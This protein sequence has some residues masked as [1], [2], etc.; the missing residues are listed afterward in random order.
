MDTLTSGEQR[1]FATYWGIKRLE[2]REEFWEDA[3]RVFLTEQL[4]VALPLKYNPV[5]VRMILDMLDCGE[6]GDCC[7]YTKIPITQQDV[8]RIIEHTSYTQKSLKRVV[9][10]KDNELYLSGDCPFLKDNSCTI[11]KWRPDTCYLFPIQSSKAVWSVD[12]EFT[13]QMFFRI[14]CRQALAVV[15]TIFNKAMTPN[16]LLLP[17]LTL[18]SSEVA[19]MKKK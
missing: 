6:C 7:R 9:Q 17:N 11:Y 19:D 2:K 13:Q 16:R 3:Y 8:E 4:N 10:T 18:I 15:R 14:K 12:G 1:L 5:T